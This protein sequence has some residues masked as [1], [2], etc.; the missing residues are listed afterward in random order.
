MVA[1]LISMSGPPALIDFTGDNAAPDPSDAAYI[2]G[3]I[4]Q[5]DQTQYGGRL[6]VLYNLTNPPGYI[7][8]P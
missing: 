7:G 1:T 2:N 5:I 6:A 3:V 4:D 8:R